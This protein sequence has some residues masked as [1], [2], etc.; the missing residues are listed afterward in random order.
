M[1]HQQNKVKHFLKLGY[2]QSDILR[3]LQSLQRDAQTNDILE[4]LIKTCRTPTSTQPGPERVTSSQ[5]SS[6][7]LIPRG[8]SSPQAQ[9]QTETHRQRQTYP[10][11]QPSS[12]FRPVVIDGSN[13]AISHGNRQVFSCRGIQLAVQWFWD[14]GVRDITVFVPLWRKEQSRPE[15]PITDQHILSE[16]ERR[17]ILVYTPSRC[18]NGKRVVCYDDRYIVKLAYDSDGII[19]SNDNYRDLQVEK[20]QWK[21][22]IEERLLMYTF[23]NDMF[24]PPDDPLGR[25]GPTIENFLRKKPTGP[26]NKQVHCPY[27]KKCTYGV[28]C[29]FYHPERSSHPQLSV[30][31]ELRA[32]SLPGC[33]TEEFP[34]STDLRHEHLPHSSYASATNGPSGHANCKATTTLP[35]AYK[36]ELTC[37]L[38]GL[39]LYNSPRETASRPT[40]LQRSLTAL[41]KSANSDQAYSSMPRLYLSDSALPTSLAYSGCSA[42][43]DSDLFL[44]DSSCTEQKRA[45]SPEVYSRA[46]HNGL[47]ALSSCQH[48][49]SDLD[50]NYAYTSY[51]PHGYRPHSP[52]NNMAT[53]FFNDPLPYPKLTARQASY[54]RVAKVSWGQEHAKARD[55]MTERRKDV[56]SQLSTIF[57]QNIVD[58]VM[59]L[60]PHTLDATELV[61]LIQK[62]RNGHLL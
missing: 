42:G 33:E 22:F 21:K 61:T 4:E 26:E 44:S 10:D 20:P 5:S 43:S 47:H 32:K 28:K 40:Y 27:G 29:K 60:Y 51:S 8:C 48:T 14:R 52:Y 41:Y 35:S 11:T 46:Y 25:N 23:A 58:Q 49:H 45:H 34:P 2:S 6:P 50:L 59:S 16:L 12:P 15:A 7:Q 30:A 53:P 38:S 17:N 19:V 55:H 39:D 62:Y 24:M 36:D 56:R 57:P 18:V 37:A 3:V 31:D 54:P 1:D 13:V 9:L